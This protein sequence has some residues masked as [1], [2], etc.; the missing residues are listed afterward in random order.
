MI[1]RVG[2]G[3][4]VMLGE[5]VT[6]GLSEAVTVG[7]SASLVDVTCTVMDGVVV[8]EIGMFEGVAVV[9]TRG[10]RISVDSAASKKPVTKIIGIAY[11]RSMRGSAAMVVTGFSP[12]Y[13]S[14]SS[15]L[16]R[17]AA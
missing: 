5:S 3:V 1:V 14:A 8:G 2:D 15:R 4:G 11:L 16:C 7:V 9:T 6:V 17:L 12:V 13:P 10:V